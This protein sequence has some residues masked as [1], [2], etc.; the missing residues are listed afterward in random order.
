MITI[1]NVRMSGYGLSIH[2]SNSK[3][4]TRYGNKVH[5]QGNQE[6]VECR[7]I[8]LLFGKWGD[9]LQRLLVNRVNIDVA[10]IIRMPHKILPIHLSNKSNLYRSFVLKRLYVNTQN[11]HI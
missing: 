3:T 4:C 11:Q 8:V 7:A 10:F 1:Y 5:T 6:T 9:N 2:L